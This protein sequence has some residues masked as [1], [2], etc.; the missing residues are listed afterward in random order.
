MTRSIFKI[1]F[2][3]RRIIKEE[4]IGREIKKLLKIYLQI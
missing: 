1:L 4:L 3:K 2:N